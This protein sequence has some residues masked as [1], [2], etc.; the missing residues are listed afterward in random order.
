MFWR[1]KKSED[2]L[3]RMIDRVWV[4]FGELKRNNPQIDEESFRLG[5]ITALDEWGKFRRETR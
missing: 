2:A 5:A 3:D 1:K 4:R